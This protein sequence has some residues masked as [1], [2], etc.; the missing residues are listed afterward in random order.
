MRILIPL[1]LIMV[2]C[3]PKPNNHD[4][5]TITHNNEFDSYIE[6]YIQEKG[7][8]LEYDIPINFGKLDKNYIGICTVWSTGHRQ[9]EI[10]REYWESASYRYRMSLIAHELGHC[11]LNKGH[12]P[13]P[14]SIMYFENWGSLDFDDLFDRVVDYAK[15]VFTNSDCVKFIEVE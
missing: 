2:S 3:A 13:Y 12:A 1:L 4:P 14:S 6:H 11:D 15:S 10:D 8:G 9:I 7:S 5:R